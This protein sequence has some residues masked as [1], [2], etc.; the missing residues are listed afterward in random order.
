MNAKHSLIL[1]LL[2]GGLLVPAAGGN[3]EPGLAAR[4]WAVPMNASEPRR[5]YQ[6]S[7]ELYRSGRVT[8]AGVAELR[9][10]GINTVV[11]LRVPGRDA[12]F[13]TRAGLNYFHIPFKVWQPDDDQVVEFL[14]IACNPACQP[15]CVYCNRGA[16]RTGMMCAA[17]RIVVQ[18]WSKEEALCEMTEGPFDYKSK[19]QKVVQYIRDM[20]VERIKQRLQQP[21]TN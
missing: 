15:V 12:K 14:R 4:Q 9:C 7:E 11:S 6:V 13:I 3:V 20:D 10:A 1:V 18:G 5:F 8:R 21:E 17:Y 2:L 16:E 19:Y